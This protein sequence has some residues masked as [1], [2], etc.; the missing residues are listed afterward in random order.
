MVDA[1][2][3]AHH[4]F[5]V[6]SVHAQRCHLGAVEFAYAMRAFQ[7]GSFEPLLEVFFVSRN[8]YKQAFR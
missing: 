5:D 7:F 3:V 2:G 6:V 1:D 8:L 4:I